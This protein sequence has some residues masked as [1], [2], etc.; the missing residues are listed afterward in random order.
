M[1]YEDWGE[2]Q[3]EFVVEFVFDNQ[4]VV[5]CYVVGKGWFYFCK[6]KGLFLAV[7]CCFVNLD[8]R[9]RY[10]FCFF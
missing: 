10:S 7:I 6:G 2:L 9:D 1:V 4:F 5:V 8:E 3:G